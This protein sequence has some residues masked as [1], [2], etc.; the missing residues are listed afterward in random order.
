MSVPAGYTPTTLA[1]YMHTV[2]GR[3]AGI[4]GWQNPAS[5]AEPINDA[6]IAYGVDAVGS[7]T[8]VDKLRACA[9]WAVWQA[10]ADYTA[11]YHDFSEDQQTFRMHQVHQ[12]AVQRAKAAARDAA[13]FGAG[14]S[15][16]KVSVDPL[17]KPSPFE[18]PD[19]Y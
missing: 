2:L 3:T 14:P 9:R 13:A 4:I 8:D 17:R 16:L 11:G 7:A 10:V 12:Q 18:V 6:L 1:T 15:A 5:Y 19:A